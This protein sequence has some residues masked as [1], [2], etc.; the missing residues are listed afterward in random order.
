MS[1]V[2][3]I[4]KPRPTEKWDLPE[5][6]QQ[7]EAELTKTRV[8]SL[9]WGE[10]VSASQGLENEILACPRWEDGAGCDYQMGQMEEHLTVL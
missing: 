2:A 4:K 10:V 6:T 8:L 1:S 7:E 9:S 5:V 3:Q